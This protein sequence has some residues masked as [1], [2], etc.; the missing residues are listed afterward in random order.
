[1]SA[2][3]RTFRDERRRRLGQ[4]FLRPELADRLVAEA[5]V[6][7]GELV[8]DVGAGRGAL[9]AAL[10]R[11]GAD[12]VAVEIDPTWADRLRRTRTR[13]SAGRLRVVNAD[14]VSCPLP[15]CPFRVVGCLPF[16]ATTAILHHLLD[17]PLVP[18]VRADVVL[19]WE[20]ARKRAA[21]PPSTLVSTAWAPWWEFRLG[22]RIPASEFRPVPKVDGA[23]LVVTRREPP[24]LPV[25]M[26]LE[27]TRFVQAQWPFCWA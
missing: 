7:P 19:Q 16:G 10:V 13:A 11:R 14:F 25:A 8:I 12:V 26:A 24:V 15:T 23:V 9:T 3:R 21:A 4:N 18:L 6:G 27:Y 22:R 2:A 17:D 20:V 5:D 1:V